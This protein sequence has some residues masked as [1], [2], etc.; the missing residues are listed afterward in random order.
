[1]IGV[2]PAYFISSFGTAFG[3]DHIASGLPFLAE[4]GYGGFQ[5]EVFLESTLPDWTPEA[6]AAVVAAAKSL[7]LRCTAFVAHFLG[8]VFSSEAALV[9]GTGGATGA[10]VSKALSIAAAFPD[11]HIFVL[12]LPAFSGKAEAARSL[13]MSRLQVILTEVEAAGFELA[14]ELMPGNVLGGSAAFRALCSGTDSG[15]GS[16]FRSLRLLFDTGHFW[17]MGEPVAALPEALASRIVATHLCDNDGIENLSLCP[18]DGTIPFAAT[19]ASLRKTS[20]AGS[21][22][23]EIVCPEHRVHNEYGRAVALLKSMEKGTYSDR[24]QEA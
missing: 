7:G 3:P 24:K 16:V 9:A 21:Y 23:V 14:L 6:T 15:S 5:A 8:G 1:M 4:A 18:G 12:P 13:F 20:Y 10:S 22:D 2:S 17:A 11:N 19:V